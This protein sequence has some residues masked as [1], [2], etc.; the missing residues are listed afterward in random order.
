[1][2]L[3]K[4]PTSDKKPGARVGKKPTKV[5][6]K[7]KTREAVVESQRRLLERVRTILLGGRQP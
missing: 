3:E 2:V 4:R 1:L 7:P 5:D 6:T